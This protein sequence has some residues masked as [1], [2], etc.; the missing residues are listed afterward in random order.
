MNFDLI[1]KVYGYAMIN[2]PLYWIVVAVI[3]TAIIF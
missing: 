3:V 2:V 1:K